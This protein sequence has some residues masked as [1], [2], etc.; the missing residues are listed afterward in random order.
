MAIDQKTLAVLKE[1]LVQEQARLREELGRIAKP[2][3]NTDNFDTKFDEIGTGE[4]ENASEIEEYTDNLAVETN[5]ENQL[6]DIDEALKKIEGDAYGKCEV[7]GNDISIERLMAY[8]S[9]KKCTS[10]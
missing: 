1:K 10:C 5:L 8:P 3:K 6:K 9:A 4:D 7:C 2:I